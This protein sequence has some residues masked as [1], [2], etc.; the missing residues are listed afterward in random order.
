MT[1][2][3]I[4]AL[5][6]ALGAQLSAYGWRGAPRCLLSMALGMWIAEGKKRLAALTYLVSEGALSGSSTG[7]AGLQSRSKSCEGK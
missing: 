2:K 7:S 5:H 1:T 6:R 4:H 3:L